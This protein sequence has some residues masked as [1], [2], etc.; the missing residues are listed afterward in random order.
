MRIP[1]II[2]NETK[3]G[4]LE[5]SKDSG[6]RCIKESPRRPPIAKLTRSRV[7][8]LRTVVL[9][10]MKKIPI[11]EIRLTKIVAMTEKTNDSIF[12]FYQKK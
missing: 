8:F 3:T 11:R 5:E 7:I 10:K 6:M 12:E 4:E 2:I 1:K 9:I